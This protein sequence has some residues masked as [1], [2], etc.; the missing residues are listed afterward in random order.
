MIPRS[1][2]MALTVVATVLTSACTGPSD[3]DATAPP[4]RGG[5]VSVTPLAEFDT[6]QVRETLRRSG[7]DSA[8]ATGGVRTLRVVYATVDPHGAPTTASG[9]V[10][11]PTGPPGQAPTKMVSWHHGTIVERRQA[12][13]TTSEPGID[14]TAAIM[15]ASA[16]HVVSAPDYLGLGTGPGHHPYDHTASAVTASIDALRATRSLP[17][18]AGYRLDDRVLLSGFS[19]GGPVTMAVGRALHEGAD[20]V[21]DIG[22]LAPI[23]GPYDFGATLAAGTSGTM[24]GAPAYLT[25]LVT[26]WDR[27]HDLYPSP[28]DA[29]RAPYDR[30][31]ETLF[32]G[33]HSAPQI[34]AELPA[35]PSELFTPEFLDQL[36]HPTG[37]LHD[38][39]RDESTSCDWAP[40]VP[41]R[42]YHAAGDQDVPMVNAEFCRRALHQRGARAD[43]V[44][45]GGVDHGTSAELALP[46][47]L[48]EVTGSR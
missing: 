33:H 18:V 17:D 30:T 13:S 24:P 7:L 25:Y 21:L 31:V 41:V 19:Q 8:Q 11:L 26:A 38:V 20:P 28:A 40:P 36:R 1:L 32:D 37:R 15:F 12:P 6:A 2:A 39:L 46:R 42:I 4:G 43:V 29:F 35:S 14:S 22:A 34:M 27:I 5:V 16:G 9:L 45:L 10:A 44:D 48:A 23:A 47:V 3:A